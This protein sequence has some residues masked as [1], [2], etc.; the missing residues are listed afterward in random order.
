M[1]LEKK[2]LNLMCNTEFNMQ[3]RLNSPAEKPATDKYY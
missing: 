1:P 2:H 3:F